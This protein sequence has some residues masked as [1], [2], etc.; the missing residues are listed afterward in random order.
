VKIRADPAARAPPPRQ[1]PDFPAGTI[2][3]RKQIL[4]ESGGFQRGSGPIPSGF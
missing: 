1:S 4:A 3:S 2:A